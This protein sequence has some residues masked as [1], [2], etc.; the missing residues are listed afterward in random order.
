M[1][2]MLLCINKATNRGHSI[3]KN[4]LKEIQNFMGSEVH[5]QFRILALTDI[6]GLSTFP[7]WTILAF[8]LKLWLHI[9]IRGNSI[10]IS[11]CK[12][13]AR[14]DAADIAHPREDEF[15]SCPQKGWSSK[16]TVPSLCF[17]S[18]SNSR[19][20]RHLLFTWNIISQKRRGEM[21]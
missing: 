4:C 1:S 18:F 19:R 9:S 21:Q 10:G 14:V 7:S 8:G 11:P 16:G 12:R 6:S 20:K 13:N 2:L 17:T 5:K 15:T 3:N